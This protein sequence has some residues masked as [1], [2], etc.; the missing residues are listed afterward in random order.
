MFSW[1]CWPQNLISAGHSSQVAL[2]PQ[3][4]CG[5][6]TFPL[7]GVARQTTYSQGTLDSHFK[8]KP[9]SLF[10]LN[11]STALYTL[12]TSFGTTEE[13][14]HWNCGKA[15]ILRINVLFSCWMQFNLW[16]LKSRAKRFVLAYWKMIV[17]R[18]G[19]L[20]F[21]FWMIMDAN[22]SQNLKLNDCTESLMNPNDSEDSQMVW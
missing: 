7:I 3:R 17:S 15:Q 10:K 18:K 8:P 16:F 9:R 6:L 2:L 14:Q 21:N 1:H 4:I 19:R 20:L 12:E 13:P 22:Y 5:R 11:V